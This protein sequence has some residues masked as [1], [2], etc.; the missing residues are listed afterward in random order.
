MN[1]NT[2][3]KI[4]YN[5]LSKNMSTAYIYSGG[6]IMSLLN[7]FSENK[8]K[9]YVPTSEMSAGFCSIGHN[10]LLNKCDSVVITTSG[11]GL[12][13]TITPITDAYCDKIPLLVS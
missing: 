9:Y 4:I 10:K 6:S 1:N 11:P 3:S 5:Y 12:T 7:H 8:M 13:N 2:V